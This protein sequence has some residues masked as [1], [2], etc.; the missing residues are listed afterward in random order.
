M[1]AHP[2]IPMLILCG[3][4]IAFVVICYGQA[5]KRLNVKPVVQDEAVKDAAYWRAQPRQADQTIWYKVTFPEG[6]G[7]PMIVGSSEAASLMASIGGGTFEP[8]DREEMNAKLD[9]LLGEDWRS[10]PPGIPVEPE[11][12]AGRFSPGYR[13]STV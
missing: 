5:S 6:K 10:K 12:I 1:I 9:E 2:N 4:I 11:P 7:V 8:A 3:S 13:R